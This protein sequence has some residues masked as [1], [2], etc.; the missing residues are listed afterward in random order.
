MNWISVKDRLP[1]INEKV[2]AI[3]DDC[4]IGVFKLRKHYSGQVFWQAVSCCD[5]PTYSI[6]EEYILYWIYVKDIP[7]PENNDV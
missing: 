3:A 5:H 6:E 7:K 1:D 2:L 4:D